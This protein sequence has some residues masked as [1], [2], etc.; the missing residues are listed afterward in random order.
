MT[1]A[2]RPDPATLPAPAAIH[3]RHQKPC[4]NPA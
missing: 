1:A 2:P 4:I 3:E